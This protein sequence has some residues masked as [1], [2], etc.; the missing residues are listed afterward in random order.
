MV[1][2]VWK[3]LPQEQDTLISLYSGWIDGFMTNLPM[4]GRGEKGRE[5]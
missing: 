5:V 2:R 4:S 1:E 3:V